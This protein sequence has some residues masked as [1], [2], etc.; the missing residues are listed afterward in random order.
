MRFFAL[1]VVI[2]TMF[3]SL[4]IS[5][6]KEQIPIVEY[7]ICNGVSDKQYREDDIEAVINNVEDYIESIG[8][9]IEFTTGTES[10]FTCKFTITRPLATLRY[11]EETDGNGIIDTRDII[12]QLSNAEIQKVSPIL[13]N[14]LAV[15]ISTWDENPHKL[16]SLMLLYALGTVDIPEEKLLHLKETTQF[17]DQEIVVDYY[18]GNIALINGDIDLAL[19]FYNNNYWLSFSTYRIFYGT[20]LAWSLIQ[21]GEEQKAIEIMTDGIEQLK[22]MGL[23]QYVDILV[24]RANLY[25]LIFDYTSSIQDMDTVIEYIETTNNSPE[26]SSIR[27]KQRGDIVMLIYEW[28]RALEDYNKAIE[29][30]PAYAEAYY[31]RGILFYTMIERENA[32]QDFEMYLEIEPD[33]EF[34]ETAIQYI[35]TIQME[36]DTLGG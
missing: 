11:F 21:K 2:S 3:T 34:S 35:E 22:G 15:S 1:I 23:S 31:R 28:N 27:Y 26:E 33:G 10:L 9:Q 7:H 13:S 14:Q 36:L 25:A 24:D 29:L 8:I 4:S 18:L 17:A 16:L 30:D 12:V 19:E 32:I 6:S 5:D 20:N